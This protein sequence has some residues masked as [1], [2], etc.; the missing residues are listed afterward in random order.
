MGAAMT[1]LNGMLGATG[2]DASLSK[3]AGGVQSIEVKSAITVGYIWI[4]TGAFALGAVILLFFNVEKKLKEEHIII[5]ERQK[6]EALSQGIEWIEPA[7]C[8]R[9]EQEEADRI[10]EQARKQELKSKE[11]I[12]IN[13]Q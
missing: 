6:S 13:K 2:Y 1:V 8:L 3:A 11:D 5:L 7:E 9:I 4:R 12:K 10:A